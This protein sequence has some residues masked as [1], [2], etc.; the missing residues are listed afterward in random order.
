MLWLPVLSS[1]LMMGAEMVHAY[2][3]TECTDAE[4]SAVADLPPPPNTPPLEFQD[5][6]GNGCIARFET[7]LSGEQLFDHYRLSARAA[8][9]A[10]EEP[11]EGVLEPG[12][13]APQSP[14][15]LGLS[16]ETVTALVQYEAAGDEGPASDQLWVVVEVH[17][18]IR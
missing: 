14:G 15:P 9:Y 16:N 5:E 1:F 11:G 17:E 13:E 7:S 3:T 2:R 4:L 12:E 6:P 10:I 8:G 18:R